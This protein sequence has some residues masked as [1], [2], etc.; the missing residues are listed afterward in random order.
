M[1]KTIGTLKFHSIKEGEAPVQVLVKLSKTEWRFLMSVKAAQQLG[2]FDGQALPMFNG[3]PMIPVCVTKQAGR[4]KS[5]IG[6]VSFAKVNGV[7]RQVWVKTTNKQGAP[8]GGWIY[9]MQVSE[10]VKRGIMDGQT[11]PI[12]DGKPV[13]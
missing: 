7:P 1:P 11:L 10:A 5:P 13:F 4:P 12:Q 2:M 6:A 3:N 9:L 8:K